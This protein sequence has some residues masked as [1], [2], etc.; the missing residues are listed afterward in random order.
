MIKNFI[1]I[2]VL[3]LLIL[4]SCSSEEEKPN[5]PPLKV[6]GIELEVIENTFVKL[7]WNASEDPNGDEVSYNVIVNGNVLASR[8]K[9]N[10]LDIDVGSYLTGAKNNSTRGMGLELTVNITAIDSENNI[11]EES[12]VKRYVFVNRNPGDFDF[13]EVNFDFYTYSSVSVDWFP[14]NDA[15][16]DLLSYDIYINEKLYVNDFVI[17]TNSNS[18][19][20]SVNIPFQFEELLDQEITIKIIANDRSG[21]VKEVSKTV[22]FR[23]TDIDLGEVS[24]PYSEILNYEFLADEVDNRIGYKFILTE[25][26]GISLTDYYGRNIEYSLRDANNNY[27]F[28]GQNSLKS[29]NLN[30]GSYYIEVKN[31]YGNLFNG[32]FN[33]I[34]RDPRETNT[35]LGSI[36]LPYSKSYD[37]TS[38]NE[39]P[40]NSII[41]TFT[42]PSGNYKYTF[43]SNSSVYFEL[44]DSNQNLLTNTSNHNNQPLFSVLTGPETFHLKVIKNNYAYN[45]INGS[46]NIKIEEFERTS[47]NYYLG[48]IST[49]F[50]KNFD[51]NN[52]ISINGR[53]RISFTTQTSFN[54]HF[55]ILAANYDTYLYLYHSNGQLIS[56]DDDGAGN[57]NLSKINGNLSPGGYYLEI[58]GYN[59]ASGS[60]VLG[61]NIY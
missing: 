22:N 41:Y 28:R 54:Y 21:G 43:S 2:S 30:A 1:F 13:K 3:I 52:S 34:F 53:V 58:G 27:I 50:H 26:T 59:D 45:E 23:A 15:D 57:G 51:Y 61:F 42:I 4:S 60:G 40:D 16:N 18:N 39:E 24:L 6:S 47:H 19:M 8:T 36:A 12:V 7:Y 38:I 20:G 37:I 29:E 33:L 11:S 17:G 9:E 32:S 35:N 55:E 44:R 56:S 10:N 48:N 46:F 31:N 14:S 25:R 49:P 5:L